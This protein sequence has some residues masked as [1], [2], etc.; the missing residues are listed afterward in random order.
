M[1]IESASRF[2]ERLQGTMGL[3]LT[4]TVVDLVEA[5]ISERDAA[6]RE[7]ARREAIE[8]VIAFCKDRIPGLRN[9]DE[10]VEFYNG[11]ASWAQSLVD[12]LSVQLILTSEAAK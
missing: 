4:E 12:H 5:K 2:C 1:A 6:I 11:A 7:S 8:E 3:P 10:R 9:V